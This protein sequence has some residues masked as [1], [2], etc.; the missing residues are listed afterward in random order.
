MTYDASS[1]E[2][3]VGLDAVRKRPGM[4][5]GD[6][7]TNGMHHC[8]AEI[9]DNAVDE[10]IAGHATCVELSLAKRS[11]VV[12]DNGRGIPV[13]KH[14]TTGRI[15]LDLVFCEL[16]AGGKFGG[17]AYKTSGGLHG[18]GASVVNAVSEKLTVNVWRDGRKY[19]RSFCRGEPIGKLLNAASS[20]ERGTQV[21]FALDDE[22]FAPALEFDPGRVR[23]RMRVKA[24]L[25]PNV[26]FVFRHGGAEETFC[27]ANGLL[28]CLNDAVSEEAVG[29]VTP[30]PFFYRSSSLQ[31]S[32]AWTEATKAKIS[33]FA[34]GVVTPMGGTHAKGVDVAVVACVRQHFEAFDEIPKK[35]Q[36]T[37]DDVREGLLAYVSV[38][39][40]NPQF[41]S[42]T[43]DR[44][45]NPEVEAVVAAEL[46]PALEEWLRQNRSQSS[47]LARRVLQSVK[48]REASRSAEL[49]A[50]RQTPVSRLRLPGKL[51]DCSSSN[52]ENSE[53]FLVEGDS[54]AGT[55]KQGRD[56][57]TQAI[58]PL[59]G[60]VLNVEGLSVEKALQNE[61]IRNIIEALGCGTGANFDASRLRYGKV[62][63]L[64]DADA[65]GH[66]IS[67]LLLAMFYRLLPELIHQGRVY[68]ALPPLYKITTK[69]DTYWAMD[70]EEKSIVLS[71]LPKRASAE[72]TRFKGLGEMPSHAL[73]ETVLDPTTRRLKQ[74][75]IPDTH[76]LR[77]E[78]L[79]RSLLGKG[80]DERGFYVQAYA[81]DVGYLDI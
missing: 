53:L 66:H 60:K 19:T 39:V 54:A 37:P 41:Q 30:I 80:S 58:L 16:H 50:R 26:R 6:N 8:I 78:A 13:D 45:N 81:E 9:L 15:A 75:D 74:I 61:E 27:Y 51:A 29:L 40:E 56:R 46:K 11:C 21:E 59:R 14:P 55:A 35:V 31:V 22:I 47:A 1:I 76:V 17:G 7:S 28:D 34:N 10:A 65:D 12:R 43:K 42:Q 73:K 24:Y 77:T 71:K 49:Q 67:V 23:D 3:L 38:F 4:Y 20:E 72:I 5:I 70:D 25:T 57:M 68:L 62:I 33:S 52:V 2:V 32:L 48:A 18:V 63:L 79:I 64:M 36:I 44:L 69:T